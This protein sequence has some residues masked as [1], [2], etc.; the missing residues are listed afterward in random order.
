VRF[1]SVQ[2]GA[3]D[4]DR[5]V[6]DYQVLLGQPG[7]SHGE[8][9][10]F[11]LERGAVEI[12]PGEDGIRALRFC[13]EASGEAPWP[14]DVA[15]YHGVPVVVAPPG[16][17]AA[18]AFPPAV[19]HAIDHVVIQSPDLDRAVRLWRDRLGLRL[20][21]DREFP[22]R[23]LRLLFFRSGG[24]TVE[25]SGALEAGG[26]RGDDSLWGVAYRVADL[27]ACRRRLLAAGAAVSESRPGQKRGTIVATAKSHALA[28]PTL[29]LQ[30]EG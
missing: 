23:G 13:R 28:V 14:E 15:A 29:L 2:I 22:Q 7:E 26:G 24:V 21:L 3:A 25:I 5:G 19:P 12:V 4:F 10:R 8:L 6:G 17:A 27:A 20:A 11:A 30:P 9:H 18:D 16:A 1:D